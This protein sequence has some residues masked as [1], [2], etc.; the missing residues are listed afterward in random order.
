LRLLA[1]RCAE[2]VR[3]RYRA[4]RGAISIDIP[5]DLKLLTAPTA[6]ETVLKN[7]LDNAL[8][9][10]DEPAGVVLTAREGEGRVH[11]SVTDQGIGISQVN[12]KLI[13]DRFYRVPDENVNTRRGTGLG[14][15]VVSS[16]VKTLGG[17]LTALSDGPGKGT[18][19][20]FALPMR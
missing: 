19:L 20:Q 13:F 15:Y 1:E 9:Y 18:T 3:G 4:P 6:L 7:L 5:E 2:R 12:L 8:K 16:L 14:L 11:F 17:R 10:S